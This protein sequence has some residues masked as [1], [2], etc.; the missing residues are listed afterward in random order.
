MV[1]LPLLATLASCGGDDCKAAPA[2]E[3]KIATTLVGLVVAESEFRAHRR[4]DENVN[5]QG[6]YGGL[7]E[8]SGSK[9]GRLP[10]TSV[11]PQRNYMKPFPW[12]SFVLNERGQASEDGYLFRLFLPGR[13]GGLVGEPAEGFSPGIV[14]ADEAEKWWVCLAWPLDAACGGY[15]LIVGPSGVVLGLEG[16]GRQGDQGITRDDIPPS[17][18]R[19][20]AHGANGTPELKSPSGKT[21]RVIAGVK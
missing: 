10:P 8:L 13:G 15:L 6:E 19:Q 4:V 2:P 3:S 17:V 7:G 5:G 12:A 11:P 20:Q 18:Y 9:R 16:A 1:V 14:D 21:W